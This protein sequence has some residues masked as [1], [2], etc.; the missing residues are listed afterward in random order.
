MGCLDV[1][2]HPFYQEIATL[3]VSAHFL[4]QRNGAVTQYVPIL[5]RAWHAGV[6]RW[7]ERSNCNDFSVGIELE[8]DDKTPFETEQYR[9][10]AQLIRTLQIRCPALIDQRIVGHQDI[11]P[12]RKWDPGPGFDWTEFRTILATSQP[13][14]EWPLV[15]E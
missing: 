3:K 13:S 12:K 6:S 14:S 1:N 2:S 7:L 4:I 10:L 8:G 5:Q 9:K 15:W 11:A